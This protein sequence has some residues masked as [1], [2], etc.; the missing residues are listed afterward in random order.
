MSGGKKRVAA[1]FGAAD[2]Y[3]KTAVVQRLAAGRLA[4]RILDLPLPPR[5]RVLEIGCG[6]GFLTRAVLEKTEASFWL[7]TDIAPA[8][9]AR[10]RTLTHAENLG[11]ACMDG[12]APAAGGGFDLVCSNL[13]FQ[14]FEHLGPSLAR[15]AELLRPGG[16]IAFSTLASGTFGEWRQAHRRL[17]LDSAT[18]EYP[19]AAALQALWPEHGAGRVEEEDITHAYP[20]GR[21]FVAALK[22]IGANAAPGRRPLSPGAFRRVLRAFGAG[23]EASVTYRVAYCLFVKEGT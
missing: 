6:T 7:A 21:A 12:E 14:W 16:H 20:D 17:G 11:L 22:D 15:L 10:C 8:M 13:A 1:L 19:N 23:G 9:L 4:R 2:A 3:E 18:P 5:P